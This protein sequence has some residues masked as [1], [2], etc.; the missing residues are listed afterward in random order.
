VGVK[1]KRVTKKRARNTDSDSEE[2]QGPLIRRSSRKRLTVNYRSLTQGVT[3]N[4]ELMAYRQQKEH[5]LEAERVDAKKIADEDRERLKKEVQEAKIAMVESEK[6]AMESEQK[7]MGNEVPE[8]FSATELECPDSPASP[9]YEDIESKGNDEKT[10]AESHGSL[11]ELVPLT[12]K[13]TQPEVDLEMTEIARDASFEE[14]RA[15]IKNWKN[16]SDGS[17]DGDNTLTIDTD[18]DIA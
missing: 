9:E 8:E 14:I 11:P 15:K 18:E 6:K 16:W 17:C 13:A 1:L 3:K 5:D 2:S 4:K 7:T 10:S 12:Q